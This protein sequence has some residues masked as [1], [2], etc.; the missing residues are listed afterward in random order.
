MKPFELLLQDN[1]AVRQLLDVYLEMRR[2][3]QELGYSESDLNNPPH[4]TIK[5][6]NLHDKFHNKF[7]YLLNYV[8]DYG[9]EITREELVQYI[10]PLLMKIN[11]VTPL[12]DVDYKRDDSGDEDY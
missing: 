3:F 1:F 2:H 9:F 11:E 7:K 6:I 8:N 5:M 12:S 4:Y 10:Q